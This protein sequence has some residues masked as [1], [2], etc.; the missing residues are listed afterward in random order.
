MEQYWK[1]APG[2][3]ENAIFVEEFHFVIPQD[4]Q[5]EIKKLL[6]THKINV[7]FSEKKKEPTASLFNAI[8]IYINE[9]LIELIVAGIILPS[10]YNAIKFFILRLLKHLKKI[11]VINSAGEQKEASMNFKFKIEETEIIAPI[12]KGLNDEQFSIYMD[13]LQETML[14]IN[15]T[16]KSHTKT[17]DLLII[18]L[19]NKDMLLTTKT[20]VQYMKEKR[21]QQSKSKITEEN[22]DEAT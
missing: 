3:Q 18:E 22:L 12:P 16:E 8:S 21:E 2:T 7:V 13:M 10:A 15:E 17:Y 19:N 14:K 20:M 5:N 11:T 6:S 9:H 4:E 1:D